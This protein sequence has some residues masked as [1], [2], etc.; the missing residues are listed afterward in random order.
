VQHRIVIFGLGEDII[1]LWQKELYAAL[2]LEGRAS[3]WTFVL[4]SYVFVLLPSLQKKCAFKS[5]RKL[6]INSP[7]F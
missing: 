6:H 1:C 7:V 5:E 2:K 3:S 4:L